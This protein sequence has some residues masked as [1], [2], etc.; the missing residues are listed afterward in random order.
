[1]HQIKGTTKVPFC[2]G[3][4]CHPEVCKGEYNMFISKNIIEYIKS[5]KWGEGNN[6]NRGLM[7]LTIN[8]KGV[9]ETLKEKTNDIGRDNISIFYNNGKLFR[10]FNLNQSKIS[11]ENIKKYCTFEAIIKI[12]NAD[13]NGIK[14]AIQ[15]AEIIENHIKNKS[16][17]STI[18]KEIL[19]FVRLLIIRGGNIYWLE[20]LA[21]SAKSD[22]DII[23]EFNKWKNDNTYL[24]A[25][26]TWATIFDYLIKYYNM[27]ITTKDFNDF[28]DIDEFIDL[29][30]QT[31]SSSKIEEKILNRKKEGFAVLNLLNEKNILN[32]PDIPLDILNYIDNLYNNVLNEKLKNNVLHGRSVL[33]KE[34]IITCPCIIAKTEYDVYPEM[35]LEGKIL[36]TT[37]T[38]PY[39]IPYAMKAQGIVTDNGGTLCHAAIIARENNIPCIVGTGIAT[40]VLKTGD[41]IEMD[42]KEGTIKF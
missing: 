30:K 2:R 36:V 16:N 11:N 18:K 9:N 25:I 37:M 27:K 28:T 33:E 38:T 23:R 15:K 7:G 22:Q 12:I 8:Q 13:N 10:V 31:N 40:E 4:I 42:L 17:Y 6:T 3:G 39:I 26:Q 5:Q 32:L 14:L 29:I 1:M 24:Q 34:A 41:V 21:E 20:G 35:D 19:E